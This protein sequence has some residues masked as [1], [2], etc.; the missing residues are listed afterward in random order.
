VNL[1]KLKFRAKYRFSL[2]HS[3]NFHCESEKHPVPPTPSILFPFKKKDT[4]SYIKNNTAYYTVSRSSSKKTLN[5]LLEKGRRD[6]KSLQKSEETIRLFNQQLS[7]ISQETYSSIGHEYFNNLVRSLASVFRMRYAFIGKVEEGSPKTIRTIALWNKNKIV[8]NLNFKLEETPCEKV[9]DQGTG[10]Y[11]ENV[12][13]YFPNSKYLAD[14]GIQSYLGVPLLNLEKKTF[15]VLSIMDENPIEDHDHYQSILNILASRC[16]SEIERM[17]VETQLKLKTNELEKSNQVMQDFV[18]IASH[19]L[20]EPVRKIAV[21]G[22]RL[23]EKGDNLKPEA[24]EYVSR[25]QKTALRMQNLIEDLLLF[26]RASTDKEPFK[27][28]DLNIILKEVISDLELLIQKNN[29]SLIFSPL[30]TIRGNATQLRQLFQNLLSNAIK[31]HNVDK[32]PKIEITSRLNEQDNWEICIKDQGIGL[33]EK[34]K[35]RIFRPFERLHGRDEFEG[36]GMGLAICQKIT[37]NLG[38]TISV[39]SQP[40]KGSCFTIIFPRQNSTPKNLE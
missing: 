39:K 8:E 6:Q 27:N 23:A 36:T 34:Y 16:A 12:Q 35:D 40:E 20:Q 13:K 21:F 28:I 2:R 19:D 31:F 37:T 4:A 5:S 32:P 3:A 29:G 1:K 38:G 7:C 14:W 11:P 18:S 26:S 30:P 17:D 24:K 22:S 33:D 25:M 9:I 10:F 15:G